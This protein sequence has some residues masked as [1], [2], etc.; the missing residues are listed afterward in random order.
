M[1]YVLSYAPIAIMITFSFV[2]IHGELI[3]AGHSHFIAMQKLEEEWRLAETC[4]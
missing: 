4:Q 3:Q 1:Q 2:C